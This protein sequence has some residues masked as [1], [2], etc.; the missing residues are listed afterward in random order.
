MDNNQNNEF[1]DENT[2]IE[3]D[4]LTEDT[5]YDE[6]EIQINTEEIKI[7]KKPNKEKK[8]NKVKKEFF[9]HKL[10][11]KNKIIIIVSIVLVVLIITLLLVYFLVIKKTKNA[12]E[13]I[14]INKTNYIYDNGVLKFLNSNN[15]EIGSYTCNDKDIK[16]CYVATYATE[17]NFDIP[18]YVD[19]DSKELELT[20]N[21]Y[22]NMYVFIYDNGYINLYDMANN[23]SEGKYSL[24]KTGNTS[25]DYVVVKDSESNKYSLILFDNKE[26]K[27]LL[28][29]YNYLGII[30]S[31]D[32]FVSKD[33]NDYYLIDLNGNKLTSKINGQLKNFNSKYIS[34]YDN[35]GYYLYNYDGNQEL[36]E[37][38]D[39][40]DF[41]NDYIFTIYDSK[42]NIYD[43]NINKLNINEIKIK[44][45][46]YTTKYVL[47]DNNNLKETKQSYELIVLDSSITIKVK[48]STNKS[49]E[50]VINLYEAA[51]N[52]KNEYISYL[53]GT[54]YI[55]RDKN[56]TDLIGTYKCNNANNI[57]SSSTTYDN[58]FIAKDSNII[59]NVDNLGYTPI[60]NDNYAFI[61]DTKSGATIKNIVLYDLAS[62]ESKAKYQEVDTG[63]SNSN[64]SFVSSTNGLIYA[65][66]TDGYYG[67]ITFSN[68]GPEGVINFK[69]TTKIIV[70]GDYLIATRDNKNYLYTKVGELLAS[71]SFDIIEYT[72][73]YLV[74]KD[75]GYLIYQMASSESGNI[76]SDEFDYIKLYSDFYVGIKDNELNVYSYSSRNGLLTT[77]LPINKSNYENSYKITITSK[78]YVISIYDNDNSSKEYYYNKDWSI[79]EE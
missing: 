74:V 62:K 33:N 75:K 29:N 45:N 78:L 66:N 31:N 70:L 22:E 20:S 14:I 4:S 26:Y 71:S 39:Y 13:D 40:I 41:E 32:I 37:K 59:N 52:K 36:N 79:E 68:N 15:K 57:T 44:S 46:D 64:I 77:S 28:E 50:T 18:K 73:N 12:T 55:Y 16:K 38:Y 67:A 60:Y 17:D 53:D 21:I 30:E 58:C 54:L 69:G 47:D 43:N 2:I 25:K 51:L 10:S 23:K 5:L 7:E 49:S 8:R 72:N 27:I 34:I 6:E 1:N 35:G 61:Y 3:L 11:K 9:W 42:M 65:K 24:I 19:E 63:L 48:E 56:K 76:I